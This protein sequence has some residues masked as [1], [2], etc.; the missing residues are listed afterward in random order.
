MK[1]FLAFLCLMGITDAL[2]AQGIYTIKSDSVKITNC[3]SSELII[4]NHT[5]DVPGFLYNTGNGRTVFKRGAIR[6]NDSMYLV[7]ADTLKTSS[8]TKAWLPKGNAGTNPLTDF[9]GTTDTAVLTFRTNNA[10]RLRLTGTTGNMLIGTTADNGARLQIN[11]AQTISDSANGIKFLIN[12]PSTQTNTTPII[13]IRSSSGAGILEVRGND[14]STVLSFP[15]YTYPFSNNSLYI[16]RDAGKNAMYNSA[17]SNAV[18]NVAIGPNALSSVTTGWFNT[19]IGADNLRSLTTGA[20]NT[21]FGQYTLASLTTGTDNIAIGQNSFKNLTTG[22][23]NTGIGNNVLNSLVSGT[24]NTSIGNTSGAATTGD[25]NVF[26]GLLAGRYETGSNKLYISNSAT[27][28]PLIYG[29]FDS[30]ILKLNASIF[31]GASTTPSAALQVRAGTAAAG[32]APIKLTP[33]TVLTTPE[34]GAI[35]YDGSDYFV[36]QG[37]TRY[38]LIKALAGQ[39]S[40]NFGG[41]SLAA[42]SAATATL[43]VTGAQPGNVVA[44]NANAG[45]NPPSILI[46]AYVSASNTVTIRAYNAGNTAVTLASDTY[47]VKIFP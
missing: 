4:E 43:T 9:I 14:D 30:S 44:V 3:N 22:S 26:I 8:V 29:Q 10:E 47:K 6:L 41:S 32:T 5:K 19:A 45:A 16:G 33:G 12:T 35:E 23:G 39:L 28:T 24:G 36:T 27:T 31:V 15:G 21:G 25:N 38:R 37:T 42:F 40:T 1:G 11:G 17:N 7:G 13:K 46:T 34:D 20:R 18:G 2:S